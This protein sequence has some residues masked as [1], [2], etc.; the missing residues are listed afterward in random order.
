VADE[1]A[2]NAC[3]GSDK[4]RTWKKDFKPNL[5]KSKWVLSKTSAG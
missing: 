3:L 5:A 4:G 1:T 2:C